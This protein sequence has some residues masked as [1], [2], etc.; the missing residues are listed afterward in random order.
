[1]SLYSVLLIFTIVI[2]SVSCSIC[3]FKTMKVPNWLIFFG[4]LMVIAVNG[5]FNFTNMWQQLISGAFCGGFYYL[6]RLITKNKLG[7]ADVYFGI[8]Q[9]LC[10]HWTLIPLCLV[11][12]VA[13][14]AFVMLIFKRR[15]CAFIP[16]MSIGLVGTALVSFFFTYS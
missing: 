7:L 14:S 11:L 3:D 1:M 15:K 10:L 8:F 4:C 2:F 13:A 9:G 16:F 6:T 12:E 5:I